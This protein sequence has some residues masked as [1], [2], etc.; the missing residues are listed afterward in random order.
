ML[1]QIEQWKFTQIPESLDVLH[2]DVYNAIRQRM[3]KVARLHLDGDTSLQAWKARLE[4][5]GYKV[6]YA[7]V[8]AQATGEDT[9][10]FGWVS[11]WPWLCIK[12]VAIV[13][14]ASVSVW[15]L[16]NCSKHC[17]TAGNEDSF[18]D[19]RNNRSDSP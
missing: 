7:P 9:Y 10:I 13:W 6:I 5:K 12:S 8:S 16:S 19:N 1:W 11:P 3:A 2:Q 18:P 17:S 4:E 15:A 14:E